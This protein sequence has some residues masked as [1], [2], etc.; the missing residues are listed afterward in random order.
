VSA[1]VG[2]KY[3]DG[4]RSGQQVG[5]GFLFFELEWPNIDTNLEAAWAGQWSAR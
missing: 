3:G 5:S 1:D 4:N 2:T